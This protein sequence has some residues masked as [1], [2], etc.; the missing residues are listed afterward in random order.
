MLTKTQ[1]SHYIDVQ[2]KLP[3]NRTKSPKYRNL[4]IQEIVL[5]DL[6]DHLDSLP[7]TLDPHDL[8]VIIRCR[9][10]FS[11]GPE[12]VSGDIELAV[13]AVD[14]ISNPCLLQ[15]FV[16]GQSL[17]TCLGLVL[18]VADLVAPDL[19]PVNDFDAD[20]TGNLH[21]ISSYFRLPAL[22]WFMNEIGVY[23][24]FCHQFSTY[25]V[26]SFPF[27]ISLG[28]SRAVIWAHDCF[29]VT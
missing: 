2:T 19:I 29:L 6:P 24:V 16:L 23:I 9:P 8:G 1:V 11:D 13:D 3:P 4:S 25:L 12:S 17:P 14:G 7:V 15:G 5:L 27:I 18:H 20:G 26:G 28:I 21:H 22:F 10:G